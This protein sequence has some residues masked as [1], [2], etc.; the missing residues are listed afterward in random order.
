MQ[1]QNF[2]YVASSHND[3]SDGWMVVSQ[4]ECFATI[5]CIYDHMKLKQGLSHVTIK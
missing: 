2:S 5:P 4:M 3:A 1:N